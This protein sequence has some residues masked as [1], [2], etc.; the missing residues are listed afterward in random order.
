MTFSGQSVNFGH[1][2]MQ[3]FD[4]WYNIVQLSQGLFSQN[5]V[6]GDNITHISLD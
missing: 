6:V 4:V 5:L 1:V 2:A 3:L